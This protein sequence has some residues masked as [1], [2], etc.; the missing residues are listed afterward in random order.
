MASAAVLVIWM[1]LDGGFV[2][3]KYWF[4]RSHRDPS[5]T[6]FKDQRVFVDH[7]RPMPDGIALLKTRRKCDTRMQPLHDFS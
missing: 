1:A 2:I 4:A 6:W 7:A 5:K 3:R